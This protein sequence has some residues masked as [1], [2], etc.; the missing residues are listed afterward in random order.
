MGFGRI[1]LRS[2]FPLLLA[3]LVVFLMAPLVVLIATS[4]TETQFLSFPPQGFTF[5]WYAKVFSDPTWGAAVLNSLWIATLSSLIGTLVGAPAAII[6]SRRG[7]KPTSLVTLLLMA[8]LTV[9]SI[10]YVLGLMLGFGSL[11]V[12]PPS[13][14]IALA[15]S[16]LTI[17]YIVRTLMAALS[18]L[19][20]SL[21][22]AAMSLGAS[23]LR[24]W[25]GILLPNVMAAYFSGL[26]LAF[27]LAFDELIV[28]LFLTGPTFPTL[29]VRIYRS[30]AY[31]VNPDLAA[32]STI[33]ILITVV[34]ATFAV[35]DTSLTKSVSK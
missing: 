5:E 28:P 19:D 11:K 23:R 7:V 30:V 35:R 14:M 25:A 16:V 17:P 34:V 27:I 2:L 22:E 1:L 26:A 6:L 20:P 32:V 3:L 18:Q 9:P 13:W 12:S 33:L 8:P 4:F 24:A 10:M 31:D 29:P 15:L 21:E